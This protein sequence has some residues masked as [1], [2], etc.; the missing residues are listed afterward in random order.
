MLAD[1]EQDKSKLEEELKLSGAPKNKSRDLGA[2]NTMSAILERQE[3]YETLIEDEKERV[4]FIKIKTGKIYFNLAL[5]SNSFMV[6]LCMIK[7]F[8]V[9]AILGLRKKSFQKQ[10]IVF[11][12][13]LK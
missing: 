7:K 3:H 8:M 13:I 10:E 12:I 5:N 1:L 4:N 2:R 6:K 11:K 9:K